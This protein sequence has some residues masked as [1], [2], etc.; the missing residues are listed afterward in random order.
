MF[1]SAVILPKIQT[2]FKQKPFLIS[3]LAKYSMEIKLHNG[4]TVY[5]DT[6]AIA[7][8]AQLIAKYPSIEKSDGF[9]QILLERWIKIPLNPGWEAKIS[10]IKPR[11]YPLGKKNEQVVDKTFDKIYHLGCLNFITEHTPFNF[12]VFLIW[13]ADVEGKRK[14]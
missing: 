1:Q 12:P 9:V 13:K 8:L 14:N 4:V 11:V 5:R 7:E 6:H 3:N 2:F 10:I